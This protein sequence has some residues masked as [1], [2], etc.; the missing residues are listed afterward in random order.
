MERIREFL[1]INASSGYGCGSGFGSYHGCGFGFGSNHGC[2]FGFSSGDGYGYGDGSG[3]GLKSFNNLAVYLIDDIQ[4]LITNV[5]NNYAKGYILNTDLTLKP[6]YVAKNDGLFAH[7]STLKEAL[8]D[9]QY[10]MFEK[11]SVEERIAHFKA[12][13]KL[14]TKYPASDYYE[15]HKKLTG[16]C[17]MGRKHFTEQQGIDLEEDSFTVL[18]FIERTKNEYG[19]EIIQKLLEA[20][21]SEV[22]E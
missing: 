8:S 9:L 22:V 1:T 4:T 16:S 5:K 18:E 3:D 19:G 6:C 14:D 7:G 2:G 21:Q 20:Y 13:F 17:E 12:A 10:K 15:W 11:Y